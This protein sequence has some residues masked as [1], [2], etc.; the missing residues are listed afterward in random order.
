M[1][2]GIVYCFESP[3]NKKYIGITTNP[4]LRYDEHRRH[5]KRLD[6]AFYRAVRKYGFE[7]FSYKVLVEVLGECK[8]ELWER[9]IVLEKEYIEKLDTQNPA[10]GYNCTAGG[11]G[12]VGYKFTPKQLQKISQSLKGKMIGEKNPRYGKI[13]TFKGK[14]H[15][16]ETKRK[17][18]LKHSGKKLSEE[19]KE[20]IRV[21]ST[22][23][24]HTA[25]SK[26][27][28]SAIQKE[29]RAKQVYC[30]ELDKVFDSVNDASEATSVNRSDIRKVCNGLRIQAKGYTF[31]WFKNGAVEDISVSNKAK[32]PFKC[33]ETGKVFESISRCCEEMNL[34]HQHVS[35]VLNGRQK[36]TKG[37]TFVF[38]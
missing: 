7:N 36:T 17:L 20:K 29:L 30:I 6:T 18:S 4:E 1:M 37:Y 23:R 31:R 12:V 11:D 21:T 2:K 32:K 25:E 9:L 24:K 22:G 14:K 33:E 27:K 3:S 34:R 38:A 35:A 26:E 19:H 15:T 28:M 13:G 16:D 8:S 10:H 5:S